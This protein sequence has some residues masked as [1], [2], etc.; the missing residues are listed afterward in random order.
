MSIRLVH[1]AVL[2]GPRDDVIGA[3]HIFDA[4]DRGSVLFDR[5]VRWQT[6]IAH[7]GISGGGASEGGAS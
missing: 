3:G 4:F 2:T 5:L 6:R 7:E 1:A